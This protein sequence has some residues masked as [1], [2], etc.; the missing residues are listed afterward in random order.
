MSMP[1]L[2][3]S[4]VTVTLLLASCGGGDATDAAGS[5]DQGHDM[6]MGGDQFAFGEPGDPEAADRTVEI[7][8]LDSLRF[9]PDSITVK[10]G[11]TI[12]FVVT[13]DGKNIHEFVLG[14]EE[15]QQ[16]HAAEMSEGEHMEGAP[17]QIDIAPGE[18]ESLTWTFAGT[19]EVVYGCHEAG[20]YQGGMVGTIEITG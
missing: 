20:H 14:D 8:A 7:S 15:Y 5:G 9:K 4:L 2:V 1:K 6:D 12:R 19:A 10:A 3:A 16:D 13:N 18:T 11:E 17:N